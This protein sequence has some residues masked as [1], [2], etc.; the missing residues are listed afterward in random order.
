[1]LRRVIVGG[2]V[3]ASVIV[4]CETLEQLAPPVDEMIVNTGET[5]EATLAVLRNG[6]DL[7]VTSCA[8]CHRPEWV[9]AYTHEEWGRILPRMSDQAG[10]S[11]EEQTAVRE[12]VTAVLTTD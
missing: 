2:I 7:Y 5:D 4:G 6:R 10:L 9:T 8:R 12:Y 1:M 3:L 11:A